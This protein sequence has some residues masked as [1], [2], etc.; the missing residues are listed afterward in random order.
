MLIGF[1]SK[2]KDVTWEVTGLKALGQEAFAGV[3]DAV[4]IEVHFVRSEGGKCAHMAS[5]QCDACF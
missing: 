3:E 1:F 5:A 2:F 4:R